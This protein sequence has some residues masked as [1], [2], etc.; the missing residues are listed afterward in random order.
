MTSLAEIVLYSAD[1]VS[2]FL[3]ISRAI[4]NRMCR[5]RVIGARKV[6]NEWKITKEALEKYLNIRR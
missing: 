5:E 4:V 1:D 3:G 2:N 6:G